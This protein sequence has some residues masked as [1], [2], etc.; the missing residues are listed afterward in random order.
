MKRVNLMSESQAYQDELT[1]WREIFAQTDPA[2][3]RAAGGLIRK[4]SYLHSLC[5]E[6]EV[7]IGAS[8]AIK[9]HPEH[10]DIQR[11]VPAVKEYAR[12]T[13]AYANVVN[14]LNQLRARNLV[15]GGDEELE[16]YDDDGA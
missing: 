13:E 16:D 12:L 11:Q 5:T 2:V 14:K 6:L 8:G 7:V 15:G 10:P 1:M 3:Q 4:A 9:V